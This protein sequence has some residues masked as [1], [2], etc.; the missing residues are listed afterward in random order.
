M[1]TQTFRY[2]FTFAIIATIFAACEKNVTVEVPEADTKIVVEGMIETGQHPIVLLTN[3]LP[4]FGEISTNNILSNSVLGA[5]VV[6]S[7]GTI[8]DTLQQIPGY[9]VYVGTT[10]TG[11]V[12]KSYHLTVISNGSTITSEA[13][14][15]A[16]VPLDSVWWKVDG[17]RDSLGFAWAHLTDPDTLGNCYRW[18]AQR[19]NHYTF[20][21]DSGKIKDSTFVAPFGGSVFDDRYINDRSFDLSFPRG[22]FAF[23]QKD[24]DQNDEK[25]RFKRGDTIVVKFSTIDRG[26]LDFWRT[27]ES[28]VSANGNP[29]GSPQPVHS[30]ITGGLGIWGA[31]SPAFDTI[32]AQ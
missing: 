4:F 3:T 7:D 24:D 18:V 29:F 23:S 11:T 2:I 28:Q 14:L 22:N 16:P 10:I 13:S 21:P 5:T 9:G 15:P 32:V 19:I 1:K 17:N 12:G 30:N 26:T 6:V 27:E 8:T 20:G 25:F 31:Y